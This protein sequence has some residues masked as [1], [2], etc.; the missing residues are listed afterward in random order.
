MRFDKDDGRSGS[1][2][3]KT[4]GAQLFVCNEER[5]KKQPRTEIVAPNEIPGDCMLPRIC[6]G[7][8]F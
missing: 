4:K 2:K 7:I 3:N 1:V 8:Q 6:R 5:H